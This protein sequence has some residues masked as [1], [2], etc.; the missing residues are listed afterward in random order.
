MNTTTSERNEPMK[1]K[2]F[3]GYNTVVRH[4][5]LDGIELVR[6]IKDEFYCGD[7]K[8]YAVRLANSLEV[9]NDFSTFK[10]ALAF[11]DK[12][13]AIVKTKGR[14]QLLPTLFPDLFTNRK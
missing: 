10:D 13:E 3:D 12:C 4:R 11:W 14:S 7:G 2:F 1:E 8:V 5:Y 9:I 6:Y